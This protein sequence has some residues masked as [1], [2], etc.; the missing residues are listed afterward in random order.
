MKI[1]IVLI[2]VCFVLYLKRAPDEYSFYT[3]EWEDITITGFTITDVT[4]P[5][6]P[7]P[8]T[9]L[10]KENDHWV[11]NLR[12]TLTTRLNKTPIAPRK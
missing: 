9:F 4:D 1:I 11:I 6:N 2:L 3:D 5:T 10:D 8:I 7:I 12:Q